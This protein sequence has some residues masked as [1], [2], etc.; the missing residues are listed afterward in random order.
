MS[1]I[2]SLGQLHQPAPRRIEE[3]PTHPNASW[4]VR[5]VLSVFN[6]I[7]IKNA[8]FALILISECSGTGSAIPVRRPTQSGGANCSLVPSLAEVNR[9]QLVTSLWN[10]A[11]IRRCERGEQGL[12]SC[13]DK[14]NAELDSALKLRD[15]DPS[16]LPADPSRCCD[17]KNSQTLS[18]LLNQYIQLDIANQNV[19]YS[20]QSFNVCASGAPAFEFTTTT[21]ESIPVPPLVSFSLA[22]N[23]TRYGVF[24]LNL[25]NITPTMNRFSDD[26]VALMTSN[27][28]CLGV[29]DQGAFYNAPNY[30]TQ[31]FF[32]MGWDD[33]SKELF[34]HDIHSPPK[35][36]TR[37]LLEDLSPSSKTFFVKKDADFTTNMTAATTAL[38]TTLA[39]LMST[40]SSPPI[41]GTTTPIINSILSNIT[42][43]IALAMSTAMSSAT[44]AA[45]TSP[46]PAGD[47]ADITISIKEISKD[48]LSPVA[49]T[50]I[51][52]GS[53]VGAFVIGLMSYFG[54]RALRT[55]GANQT[56]KHQP[57]LDSPNVSQEITYSQRQTQHIEESLPQ[58]INAPAASHLRLFDTNFVQQGDV[59]SYP[60][61]TTSLRDQ[62]TDSKDLGETKEGQP[63]DNV[64]RLA[65]FEPARCFS[66]PKLH[67]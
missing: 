58:T 67:K 35:N 29:F 19:P 1:N 25:F 7:S 2:L 24:P 46:P 13:T 34:A 36:A 5:H 52:V 59:P 8:L 37:L 62:D 64:S 51:A 11:P 30:S 4:D 53:A 65:P 20:S 17:T 60:K 10:H 49:I 48:S 26:A 22:D 3:T 63:S 12:N 54:F 33:R 14:L 43:T 23:P 40:T 61:R 6:D 42:Y 45:T 39:Q 55:C 44:A 57:N 41:P 32:D 27:Q 38:S 66:N 28:T 31:G 18:D 50:G 16:N 56:Q 21:S 15:V 9:S 47:A